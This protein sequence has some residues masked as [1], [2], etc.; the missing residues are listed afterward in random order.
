MLW[1]GLG[2]TYWIGP[3]LNLGRDWERDKKVAVETTDLTTSLTESIVG[4]R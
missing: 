4:I 3:D 1:I 2:K